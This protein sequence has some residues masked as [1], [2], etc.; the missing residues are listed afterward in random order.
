MV[1]SKRSCITVSFYLAYF[2]FIMFSMLGHIPTLGGYLKELT[3]FGLALFVIII[4]IRL[5]DYS[6]KEGIAIAVFF[7]YGL[8]LALRT[9]DYGIFKLSI[10]IFAAKG[11]DFRKCVKFDL[12]SRVILTVVLL[13]LFNR[14][15]APDVTSYYNGTLRHSIGFQNPNHV[16]MDA[17]VIIAEI[18]YVS[19]MKFTFMKFFMVFGI[20]FVSDRIAGSRTAE[21]ITIIMISLSILYA[22]WPQIYQ[23][24]AIDITVKW[25][26]AICSVATWAAVFLYRNGNSFAAMLNVALSNRIEN[27]SYHYSMFGMS[28]F[29]N[30]ISVANRTLDSLYGYLYISLGIVAFVI[31]IFFYQLLQGKLYSKNKPL[32]I[33]IFCFFLYG[34]SERLW[35]YIDYNVFMLSFAELIYSGFTDDKGKK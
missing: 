4:C 29:G 6:S 20:L 7:L 35:S 27:I 1:V 22:Y 9:K 8:F 10:M 25:G 3:N 2:T 30:D 19:N 31:Y 21:M 23:K 28:L 34:L 12:Y 24:K 11:M 17:F 5:R 16:G 32:A 33:I 13:V 15:I 18:L 14:G 26:A